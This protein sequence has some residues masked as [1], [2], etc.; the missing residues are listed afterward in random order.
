MR[1]RWLAGAI[2]VLAVCSVL[3]AEDAATRIRKAVEHST[4]DQPGTPPFHLK[5]VVSPSFERD[6]DSGRNGAVEIWW[7]SPDRWR[8]ELRSPG[9]HQV[10]IMNNGR[11]WQQNDGD[12][13]PEWLR[14]IALEL[15]RPVPPLDEVLE[16]AKTAETRTLMGKQVNIDWTTPTG[17]AEVHNIQRSG[18]ALEVATVR[19]LYAYGFGWGGDFKDVEKFHGRLV[20]R[21]V[22]WGTPEVTAKV[23][24][25]EE[26]GEVPAG[27][28]DA[29][30][31][32]GDLQL[33]QTV[34]IDE[35]TLRKNLLPTDP[36]VWLPIQDG[37]LEGNVTTNVVVDRAGKV[38]EIGSIVSENSA[39]NDVGRQR[40]LALQFK[41]FLQNGVAIQVMS[42]ITLPFKT[43]RPAGGEAF[44][45]ARVYFERGRQA[46]FPAAGAAE[47]Y[48]MRAEFDAMGSGGTVAKGHYEDIWLSEDRWRRE[49]TFEKSHYVRTRSGEKR[50]ELKEGAS[51]ALLQLVFRI[52]EPI[53][54]TDT[55]TESDW[56]IKQETVNGVST[57]RVLAGYESPD[58]QLD[59]E[60]ARGFWFDS[61]GLLRKTFFAGIETVRSDFQDFGGVKVPRRIDVLKGGKLAMQI[62]IAD[63]TSPEDTPP[64]TFE[65]KGHAWQR[66]FTSEMR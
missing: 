7:A 48:V 52:L 51:T 3:Q 33:L 11:D 63:L 23:V 62:S 60:Q 18:V 54:A 13:L 59:A 10:E 27:F 8:R 30:A 35:T 22:N 65:L 42:Q 5:A 39:V 1:N 20:A 25:L 28:F 9:F 56:R 45:S 38:R 36:I 46:S 40:I 12:F 37:S 57:V 19:L 34:L 31:K 47:P 32:G 21:S 41:P 44:D 24:T 2:T 6:K 58:G 66:A 61:A 55:F 50:Y 49:A 16:H 14:E 53:P 64:I 4:L 15:I 29:E 26:L 17:T 43:S